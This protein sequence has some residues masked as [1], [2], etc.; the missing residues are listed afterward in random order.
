[1][2]AWPY[3]GPLQARASACLRRHLI[4]VKP[5]RCLLNSQPRSVPKIGFCNNS[6][7]G[8]R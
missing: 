1:M 2:F 4:V 8:L 5:Q 7:E 3:F 6:D